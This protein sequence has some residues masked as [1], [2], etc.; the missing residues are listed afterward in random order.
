VVI[1]GDH[2]DYIICHLAWVICWALKLVYG[3]AI[4]DIV[5]EVSDIRLRALDGT[6]QFVT[7]WRLQSED[8]KVA[9]VSSASADPIIA[10]GEAANSKG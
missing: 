5:A 2:C 3:N 9:L 1:A 7:D 4:N 6:T 10:G 8:G